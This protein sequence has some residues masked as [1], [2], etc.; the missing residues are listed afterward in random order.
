VKW[1]GQ[2]N[3][4]CWDRFPS[5]YC[6]D[7]VKF[8]PIIDVKGLIKVGLYD[9]FDVRP[10][11]RLQMLC[12]IHCTPPRTK[13]LGENATPKQTSECHCF[14]CCSNS[15]LELLRRRLHVR[16][17]LGRPLISG[18][19]QAYAYRSLVILKASQFYI[20]QR[21]LLISRLYCG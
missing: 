5:T 12:R 19:C 1:S 6:I 7:G 21:F 10:A 13:V 17:V 4:S 8:K 11:D 16:I 20:P 3:C 18:F 15:F 9:K 14:C 2:I